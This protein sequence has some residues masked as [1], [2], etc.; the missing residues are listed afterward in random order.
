MAAQSKDELKI[1]RTNIQRCLGDQ[2][3]VSKY[4]KH[5][6]S[7]TLH[8]PVDVRGFTDFSCS[9]EHNENASMALFGKNMV[10][11]SFP[12]FPMAYSGRPSSIVVSGTQIRRPFGLYKVGDR[13]EYGACRQLDYELEVRS[14]FLAILPSTHAQRF[15]NGI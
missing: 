11:E 14:P 2:A 9:K 3:N 6:D 5:M 4:G 10:P 15:C 8:L 7:V 13:V 12:H 1:L